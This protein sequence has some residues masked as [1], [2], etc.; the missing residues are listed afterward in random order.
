[1][2]SLYDEFSLRFLFTEGRR[3]GLAPE[4]ERPLDCRP[5]YRAGGRIQRGRALLDVEK[6]F[7]HISKQ[8]FQNIFVEVIISYHQVICGKITKNVIL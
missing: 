5:V 8:N 7:V 3:L 6:V 1:M 4:H 2:V